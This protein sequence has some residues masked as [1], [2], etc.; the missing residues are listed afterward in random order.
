MISFYVIITLLFTHWFADFVT[1]SDYIAQNKSKSNLVLGTHI[2]LYGLMLFIPS[3]WLF[4]FMDLVIQFVGINMLLHFSTDFFT[5]RITSVLW[6]KG[7]VHWFFTVIGFDQ[8]LHCAALF[9]TYVYL[10]SLV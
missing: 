9:G 5:S 10:Q 3:L 4:P 1:Q 7:E 8:F 2:G 6:K